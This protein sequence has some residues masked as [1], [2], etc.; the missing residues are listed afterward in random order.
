MIGVS[1][2]KK[3]DNFLMCNQSTNLPHNTY[4]VEIKLSLRKDIWYYWWLGWKHGRK[5][6]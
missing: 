2:N 6:W 3:A 1:Y 4:E 5:A